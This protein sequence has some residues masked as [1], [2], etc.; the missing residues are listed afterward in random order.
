[1]KERGTS[2]GVLAGTIVVIVVVVAVVAAVILINSNRSGGGSGGGSKVEVT[3]TPSTVHIGDQATFT[4]SVTNNESG[5]MTILGGTEKAYR[6]G[7]LIDTHSSSINEFF[8]TTIP[9]GQTVTVYSV[10]APVPSTYSGTSMVGTWTYALSL[11]TNYG[12]LTDS[13]S[14]TVLS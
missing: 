12:A 3:N 13:C 14:L 11:D 6:N 2:T 5:T 8:T 4:I 1:V 9:A 7:Q 10:T